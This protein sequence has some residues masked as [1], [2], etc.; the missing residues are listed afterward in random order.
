MSNS[1]SREE[2]EDLWSQWQA[3]LDASNEKEIIG[4]IDL[5][6]EQRILHDVITCYGYDNVNQL[7]EDLEQC[8]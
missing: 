5:A 2:K 3:M 1:L 4:C 6:N 7:R 8:V